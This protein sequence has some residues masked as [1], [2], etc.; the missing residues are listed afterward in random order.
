MVD[1]RADIDIPKVASAFKAWH[2]LQGL[3]SKDKDKYQRH[4]QSCEHDLVD[5]IQ[6]LHYSNRVSRGR[7]LNLNHN[8]KQRNATLNIRPDRR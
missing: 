8:H 3:L 2:P 1:P 7:N 5:R 4:L 6:Y